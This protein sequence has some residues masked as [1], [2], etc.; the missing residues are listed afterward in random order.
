VQTV[1][2]IKIIKAKTSEI[3]LKFITD[4]YRTRFFGESCP[5]IVKE[6]RAGDYLAGKVP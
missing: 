5:S 1:P 3:F 4:S 2:N 6:R